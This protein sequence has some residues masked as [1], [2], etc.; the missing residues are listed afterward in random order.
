MIN[1]MNTRV[2][3]LMVEAVCSV[4]AWN[5]WRE[6]VPGRLPRM[7]GRESRSG[8]SVTRV[9]RMNQTSHS[10]QSRET[11]KTIINRRKLL[12]SKIFYKDDFKHLIKQIFMIAENLWIITM[13]EKSAKPK[14]T[15]CFDKD[16]KPKLSL[17]EFEVLDTG[18]NNVAGN[19]YQVNK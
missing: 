9:W 7:R 15:K 19:I 5:I 3:I 1:I 8:W 13:K 16:E 4:A 6:I 12:V 17:R 11:S 14:E 10:T 18:S 2:C